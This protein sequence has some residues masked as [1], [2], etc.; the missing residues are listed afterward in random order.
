[1][2][3]V[4]LCEGQDDLWFIS[5]FLHKID[6]WMMDN[7]KSLWTSYKIPENKSGRKV[8]YMKKDNDGVA[9]WSVGG[10]DSFAEPLH[11]IIDKFV[12]E[13]PSASPESV[14]IVRDRDNDDEKEILAGMAENIIDGLSLQ[15]NTSTMCNI[16]CPNGEIAST[17][18]TPVIFP[19]YEQGAIETLLM[20]A[21]KEKNESGKIIYEEA[22]KYVS[23]LENNDDVRKNYLKS[24]RLVLKAKYSSMI[25]ITNPDHSTG[26][27]KDMM[28]STPWEKSAYVQKHFNVILKAITPLKAH[29]NITK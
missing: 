23:L 13:I 7:G 24:T 6:G 15:N 4:I 10:K 20:N 28:L 29:A 27:F 3:S 26:L 9:I 17:K 12:K 1:M 21:V 18:I 25:A 22:Q 5:Y 14:V 16:E 8:I 11:I 19:F 2:K